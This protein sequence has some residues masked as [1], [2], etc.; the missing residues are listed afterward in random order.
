MARRGFL[1]G[2][3]AGGLIGAVVGLVAAPQRKPSPK[4]GLLGRTKRAGVRAQKVINEVRDGIRDIK[5]I[6]D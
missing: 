6:L 2:L 5:N 4:K 1:N 3:L